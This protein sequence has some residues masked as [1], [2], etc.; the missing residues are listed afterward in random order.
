[1]EDEFSIT[2]RCLFCKAPLQA[3]ESA[4]FSS[5]DMIKCDSCGELNDYDSVVDVA[6]EEAMERV[7]ANV[8]S[9]IKDIFKDTLK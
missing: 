6:K 9:E 3:E 5:G 2:V 7:K 1:M 8:E 4:E